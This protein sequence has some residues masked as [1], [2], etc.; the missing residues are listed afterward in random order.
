VLWNVRTYLTLFDF[1]AFGIYKMIG[2]TK[3]LMGKLNENKV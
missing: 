3:L 2:F 1:E